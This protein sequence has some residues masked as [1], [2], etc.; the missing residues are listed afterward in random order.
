MF[1]ADRIAAALDVIEGE[2][3]QSPSMA[4]GFNYDMAV[5]ECTGHNAVDLAFA[6]KSMQDLN[7]RAKAVKSAIGQ[8]Y[9]HLRIQALPAQ[10]EAEGKEGMKVTGLGRVTLTGDMHVSV[11]NKSE[12][13][14]WLTEIGEEELITE[15]VNA[16][17]LK[18]LLRRMM[19]NGQ[20]VPEDLFRITLFTRATVTK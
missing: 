1:N 2:L 15:T 10:M 5:A 11:A 16:S 20:E 9:D 4:D 18:A 13:K 6:L 19:R 12:A 17:S 8:V 14:E 3:R 7:D